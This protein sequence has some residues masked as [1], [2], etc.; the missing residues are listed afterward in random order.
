MNGTN[1]NRKYF[2]V[3]CG[4]AQKHI[5]QESFGMTLTKC[6][7]TYVLIIKIP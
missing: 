5:L 7:I 1:Q 6:S 2:T 4:R 3:H